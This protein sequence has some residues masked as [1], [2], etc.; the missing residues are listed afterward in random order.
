MTEWGLAKLRAAQADGS[1][2]LLDAVEAL[3]IPADLQAAFRKHRGSA[4]NF[5]AF[6]PSS[7][8]G[9]LGWIVMAKRAETRAARVEET[10]RLAAGNTRANQ[11]VSRDRRV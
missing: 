1:W 10:A 5:A 8:H 6:P 4:K 2:A 3:E 11:W 7:K 9:I